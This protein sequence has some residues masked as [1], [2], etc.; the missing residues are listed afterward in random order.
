MHL[1]S[2][3]VRSAPILRSENRRSK[4]QSTERTELMQR[5]AISVSEQSFCAD[6]D[7]IG[8]VGFTETKQGLLETVSGVIRY[9]D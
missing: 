7:R 9:Q 8:S 5:T 2:S 3:S 1:F 4:T 6:C